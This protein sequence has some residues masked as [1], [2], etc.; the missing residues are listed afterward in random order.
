MARR[1]SRHPL[2]STVLVMGGAVLPNVVRTLAATWRHVRA[3]CDA[4]RGS[5]SRRCL[6]RNRISRRE[7]QHDRLGVALD[8]ERA[9]GFQDSVE[10]LFLVSPFERPERQET[11][12]A[13]VG[14][15]A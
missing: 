8:G 5:S 4:R 11:L 10:I 9:A 3:N 1:A 12:E 7:R 13:G 15:R 2:G 14:P 6:A